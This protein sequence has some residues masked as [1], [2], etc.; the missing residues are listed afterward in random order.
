MKYTRPDIG[1]NTIAYKGRRYWVIELAQDGEFDF[2]G[3][4]LAD[5]VLWDCRFSGT[6]ATIKDAKEGGVIGSLHSHVEL[7]YSFDTVEDAAKSLPELFDS[8]IQSVS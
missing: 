8:Y 7:S 5:Y 1:N 2:V 4:E 6:I 3:K